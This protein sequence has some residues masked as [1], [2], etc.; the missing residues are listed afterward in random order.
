MSKSKVPATFFSISYMGSGLSAN[1]VSQDSTRSL[2]VEVD[3]FQSIIKGD[4]KS[5][6]EYVQAGNDVNAK[7]TLTQNSPL[8]WACWKGHKNIAN[9]LL[10]HDAD[11]Y[12]KGYN[13][14]TPLHLAAENGHLHVVKML[15]EKY[16]ADGNTKNDFGSTPLHVACR[17]GNI[18]VVRYLCNRAKV[19]I[20]AKTSDGYTSFMESCVY[21]NYILVDYFIKQHDIDPNYSGLGDSALQLAAGKGRLAVVEVLLRRGADPN[22]QSENGNTALHYA[23]QNGHFEVS[24]KLLSHGADPQIVNESQLT[25][26]N[27]AFRGG[28]TPIIQLS[29]YHQWLRQFDSERDD[30]LSSESR[31]LRRK[32]TNT[33][34]LGAG[35]NALGRS[36]A[37]LNLG[38]GQSQS[39][40]TNDGG[41]NLLPAHFARLCRP[42]FPVV[43][44][45]N[46]NFLRCQDFV[47]M[48]KLPSYY[49]CMRN[50]FLVRGTVLT[51]KSRVLFISHR[52]AS[53]DNP[54]NDANV[55]YLQICRFLEMEQF[56]YVWLDYACVQRDQCHTAFKT[57]LA[58]VATALLA[59]THFLVVPATDMTCTDLRDFLDRAWCQCEV[60]CAMT[61]GRPVS[62]VLQH[63]NSASFHLLSNQHKWWKPT[64]NKEENEQVHWFKRAAVDQ[65]L[66][67]KSSFDKK[68]QK[69]PLRD[70]VALNHRWL[71]LTEPREKLQ[72]AVDK[73][74][75]LN[76]HHTRTF[77]KLRHLGIEEEELQTLLP[78]Y[79][80]SLGCLSDE[81]DRPM[82]VNTLFVVI[83]FAMNLLPRAPGN[84]NTLESI[85][86]G[87]KELKK[88]ELDECG[89][90]LKELSSALNNSNSAEK[91]VA[92]DTY[93]KVA[94]KSKL[95]IVM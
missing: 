88:M 86:A 54:D 90:E 27:T 4:G 73:V 23:C 43:S 1:A 17:R 47:G 39:E 16:Q 75:W 13:S 45:R 59:A 34:T 41:R 38:L 29:I 2:K 94:V 61:L 40:A 48:G 19:D 93:V 53:W 6:T 18:E 3:I 33:P 20:E 55:K 10:E 49:D 79:A 74:L 92:N 62:V 35:L 5:V 81:S 8:H 58:N 78:G 46:T 71:T 24:K 56:E 50:S 84:F 77:H 14:Y 12:S 7:D 26:F 57:H 21:G 66:E 95:C 80:E 68:K 37:S 64:D 11:L 70:L 30:S 15:I 89:P 67:I 87:P 63:L 51:E 32:L 91:S 83:A 42:V 52:W 25:A 65:Y 44:L 28:H 76:S 22:I 82:V 85:D 31:S 69:M 60:L 9:Y 36:M 72:H